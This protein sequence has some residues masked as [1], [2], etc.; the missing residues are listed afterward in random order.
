MVPPLYGGNIDV[1]S[2]A[3]VPR[4]PEPTGILPTPVTL[5]AADSANADNTG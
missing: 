4:V 2:P 3:I 1:S 5:P